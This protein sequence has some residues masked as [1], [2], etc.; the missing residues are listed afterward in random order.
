MTQ[1]LSKDQA[2]QVATKIKGGK[3]Y[4]LE[5]YDALERIWYS[6][7]KFRQQ[8]HEKG[9]TLIDKRFEEAAFLEYLQGVQLSFF[10]SFIADKK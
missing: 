10:K 4:T 6:D 3:E 5:W 2:Q 7:G 9:R 8:V 1:K